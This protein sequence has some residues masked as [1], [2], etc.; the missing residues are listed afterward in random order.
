MSGS[1]LTRQRAASTFVPRPVRMGAVMLHASGGAERAARI[2]AE[3]AARAATHAIA[4]VHLGSL[5]TTMMFRERNAPVL[6]DFGPHKPTPAEH[7]PRR[8]PL[9]G[10]KPA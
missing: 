3:D 4:H 6:S 10:K 5:G 8:A 2:A 9:P 7:K 1:R